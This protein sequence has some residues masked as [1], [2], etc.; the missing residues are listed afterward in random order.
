MSLNQGTFDTFNNF[1]TKG[2][3]WHDAVRKAL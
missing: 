1:T 3:A 2:C